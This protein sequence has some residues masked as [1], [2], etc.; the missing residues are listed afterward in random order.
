[1]RRLLATTLLAACLAAAAHA[2]V[3]AAKPPPVIVVNCTVQAATLVLDPSGKLRVIEYK[4]EPEKH[5]SPT[6]TGRVIVAADRATRTIN[7]AAPCH[8]VKAVQKRELG[9]AGPW[10]RSIESRI[11]CVSPTPKM[12]IDLQ[13]RPVLDR[14]HRVVG[15]RVVIV[16][17]TVVGAGKKVRLVKVAAADG[18]VTAT[19]GGIRFEPGFCDRNLYP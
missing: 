8:R 1:M 14:T 17:K 7:P 9:F 11:T 19:G 13:L 4:Y 18:W 10:P 16:R 2:S 6:S 3:D 5:I 12:G 15:N